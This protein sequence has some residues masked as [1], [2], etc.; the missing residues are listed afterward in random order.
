MADTQNTCPGP[1]VWFHVGDPPDAGVLECN[2][3]G[4]IIVTGTFNDASHSETP[5]LTGN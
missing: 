4:Y 2:T 1:L 5:V 3:C